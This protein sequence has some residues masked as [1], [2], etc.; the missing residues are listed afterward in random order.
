MTCWRRLRDWHEAGVWYTLHQVLLELLSDAEALDWSRAM[1]DAGRVPA[2]NGAPTGPNPTD[3]GR[4]GSK[5]HRLTEATGIP[6]AAERTAA[7]VNEG[8]LLAHMVDLVVPVRRRRGVPG[9]PQ[10]RPAK[11]HADKAYRSRKD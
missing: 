11:L 2:K 7:N 8:T 10:K 1:L 5:H 4:A 6:L 9:R 3:R